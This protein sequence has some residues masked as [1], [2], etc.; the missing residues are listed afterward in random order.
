MTL[1]EAQAKKIEFY[2][3][4]VAAWFNTALERDKSLLTLSIAGLG[5]LLASM[6]TA[7]NSITALILYYLAALALLVCVL[8][9]LL[10]FQR[11]KKH[12]QDVFNGAT[13]D[14]TWLAV[15]DNVAMWSFMLGVLFCAIIGISS[16]TSTY[17]EKERSMA[18]EKNTAINTKGLTLTQESFNQMAAL[19]KSFNGLAQLQPAQPATAQPA[20][21][22]ASQPQPSTT[23]PQ[24]NS[25]P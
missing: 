16:A 2:S 21:S 6:P 25:N 9:V 19:Q 23:P 13:N 24:G 3:Q 8:S 1:E 17:F 10:I 11:N 20:Q 14:D 15:L 5:F 12:I 7:V 4:G 22:S 18:T